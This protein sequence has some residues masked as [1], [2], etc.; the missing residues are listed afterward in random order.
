MVRPPERVL[1]A[2]G[3]LSRGA[4]GTVEGGGGWMV[5]PPERV[6]AATGR[7]SRGAVRTLEGGGW[8]VRPPERVLAAAGRLSRGAVRALGAFGWETELAVNGYQ[9]D[10]RL[11][12]CGVHLTN[13]RSI[14]KIRVSLAPKVTLLKGTA[15]S[16]RAGGAGT[17]I[18]R[19]DTAITGTMG[20][21]RAGGA[22]TRVET[23]QES[24][25]TG[26]VESVRAGG[27][28]TWDMAGGAEARE[29]FVTG[30]PVGGIADAGI[31]RRFSSVY[32]GG[33]LAFTGPLEL[34]PR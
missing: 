8:M 20:S 14:S 26:A 6:L 17:W 7:L 1:A 28:E 30:R 3:R 18:A 22:E 9:A 27:N 5:R 12:L 29:L 31:C 34:P 10:V 15:Q 19:R 4:V 21:T 11:P 24:T 33:E 25:I 2:T 13:L 16:T 23:R 32:C